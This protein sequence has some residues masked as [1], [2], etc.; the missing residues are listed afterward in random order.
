[1]VGRFE[2]SRGGVCWLA[3]PLVVGRVLGVLGW[4][5]G[6]LLGS[7]DAVTTSV[8]T[9]LAWKVCS[10]VR[11]G[12][13]CGARSG[14]GGHILISHIGRPGVC[15]GAVIRPLKSGLALEP[16]PSLF[17]LLFRQSPPAHKAIL[18]SDADLWSIIATKWARSTR[19][20][21]PRDR[22]IWRWQIWL[23]LGGLR[24]VRT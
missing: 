9:V 3:T 1:V 18:R 16:M 15:A 7:C 21:G 4:W 23:A 8:V 24:K 20:L 2:W 19:V 12:V 13:R 10:G 22:T 11:C 5:L 6:R 14:G 17:D